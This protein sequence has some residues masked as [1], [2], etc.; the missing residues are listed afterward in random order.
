MPAFYIFIDRFFYNILIFNV[1]PVYNPHPLD[2]ATLSISKFPKD[3]SAIVSAIYAI[4]SL[5]FSE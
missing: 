1:L 5:I 2:V 3:V 4:K